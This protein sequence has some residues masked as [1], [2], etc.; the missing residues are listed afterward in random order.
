MEVE[1]LGNI[2]MGSRNNGEGDTSL[3][4]GENIQ[5][6]DNIEQRASDTIHDA[7]HHPLQVLNAALDGVLV[8]VMR[9][10]LFVLNDVH[11]KQVF[12][13]ER[14]LPF[15]VVGLQALHSPIITDEVFQCCGQLGLRGH[16]VSGEELRVD[17]AVDLD[18]AAPTMPRDPVV[19]SRNVGD[20]RIG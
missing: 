13:L 14:S 11:T 18:E 10:G 9:L 6:V 3:R 17:T 12:H 7:M 8:L 15:C 20:E 16:G 5:Q 1:L 4:I 19:M 2:S